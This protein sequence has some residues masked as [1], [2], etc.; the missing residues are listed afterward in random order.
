[1][2][3][4]SALLF[5]TLASTACLTAADPTP[6]VDPVISNQLRSDCTEMVKRMEPQATDEQR[7]DA[8]HNVVSLIIV[9][10]PGAFSFTPE[11]MELLKK[12]APLFTDTETKAAYTKLK[13]VAKGR[14]MPVVVEFYKSIYDSGKMNA[15]EPA[16]FVRLTL[17]A[18]AKT[19]K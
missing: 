18:E 5:F 2:R 4:Y 9:E 12:G 7:Q 11:Q 19:S 14:P 3:A 15:G 16:I 8:V 1:M 6:A 17:A 10:S 13:D